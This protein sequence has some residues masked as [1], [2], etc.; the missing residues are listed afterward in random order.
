VNLE[1]L[2]T[3]QDKD[4]CQQC[5][6]TRDDANPQ[7]SEREDTDGDQIN[8]EQKHADVFGNHVVSMST[9]ADR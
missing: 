4:A 2:A 5:Q 7:A 6:H 1:R 3:D 9:C 8:G